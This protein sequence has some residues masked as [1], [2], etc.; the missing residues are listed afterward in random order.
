M[1][2]N[3][4]IGCLAV[5]AI[6]TLL[7]TH[8]S[9][10]T[11]VI[12]RPG[13]HP[14]YSFEAEPHLLIGPYDPPGS[15]FDDEAGIGVGFRGTIEIV[16]NGFISKINNT[17]GIGFGLD[18][19]HFDGD[20]CVR[21]DR[22]NGR[23]RCVDFDNRDVNAVWL[24][25]VMQWNFWLS[26]NWSVFGEPGMAFRFDNNNVDDDLDFDVDFFVFYAGGRWHFADR[27]SLTMRIGYPTF[28]VGVSFLL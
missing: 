19:V 24:P 16:D 3:R 27:M 23:R 1:N 28:S 14:R 13:A 8:A 17:V 21:I 11:M 6:V 20:G 4:L 7:G 2:P 12:K 26:R 5:V 18:F 22:V 9:A 10:D 25:V 15:Q